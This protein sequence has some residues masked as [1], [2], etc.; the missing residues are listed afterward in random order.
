MDELH[1][2]S[3][4]ADEAAEYRRIRESMDDL[5]SRYGDPRTLRRPRVSALVERLRHASALGDFL[6]AS[7]TRLHD[8]DLDPDVV[9]LARGGNGAGARVVPVGAWL[10]PTIGDRQLATL[11]S[12]LAGWC[13]LDNGRPPAGGMD[14]AWLSAL[15]AIEGMPV[16]GPR[17]LLRP[18]PGSPHPWLGVAQRLMNRILVSR[19]ELALRYGRPSASWRY[20]AL[21]LR[22]LA[23]FHLG[24]GVACPAPPCAESKNS[25][26]HQQRKHQF[27]RSIQPCGFTLRH[28]R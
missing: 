14:E 8:A 19:H 15:A 23:P 13:A 20:P 5:R 1:A 4:A 6:V 21:Q 11:E 18:L 7:S 26:L 27:V 28:R 12:L 2:M 24:D 25:I 22:P 17:T 9:E 10:R 3:R 16:G